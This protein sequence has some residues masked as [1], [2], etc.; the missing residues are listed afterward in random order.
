MHWDENICNIVL[1]AKEKEY[2]DYDSFNFMC[3]KQIY[4]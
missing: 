2:D 4:N 3:V 1:W